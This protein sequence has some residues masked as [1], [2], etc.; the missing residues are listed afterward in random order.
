MSTGDKELM[1]EIADMALKEGQNNVAFLAYFTLNELE[2]CL[3]LLI[4]TDRLAEAAFFA[5]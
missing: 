1:K 5:R 3:K 2:T 4:D